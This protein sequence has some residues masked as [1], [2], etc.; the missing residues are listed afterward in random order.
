MAKKETVT[1]DISVCD[2]LEKQRDA[3]FN[4]LMKKSKKRLLDMSVNELAKFF[5]N[6]GHWH[7]MKE[8]LMDDEFNKVATQI[9]DEIKKQEN[10]ED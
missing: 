5:F 7:G 4:K 10:G 3:S 2:A 8:T 1:L 6:S 9:V